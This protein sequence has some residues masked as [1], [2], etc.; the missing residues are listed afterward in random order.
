MEGI[1]DQERILSEMKRPFFIGAQCGTFQVQVA[2]G[3]TTTLLLN[4]LLPRRSHQ[5]LFSPLI[6]QIQEA[7]QGYPH[8]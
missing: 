2:P 3:N 5:S 6:I 7:I 8:V 1:K 4:Q